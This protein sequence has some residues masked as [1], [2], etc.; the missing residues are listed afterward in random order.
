[1]VNPDPLPTEPQRQRLCEMMTWAFVE[2]RM[3]GWNGHAQQAA[4]LA[5]AFHNLPQEMYGCGGWWWSILREYLQ[6]YQQKYEVSRDYVA[7]LDE[8]RALA[9]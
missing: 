3:L 1:M 6:R 7:K 5:D 4:D 9:G 2:I 8:I